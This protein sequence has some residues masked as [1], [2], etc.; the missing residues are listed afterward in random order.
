MV[1]AGNV[2]EHFS[3]FVRLV[4][5]WII[6]GCFALLSVVFGH[7]FGVFVVFCKKGAAHTR[8]LSVEVAAKH[9]DYCA[10]P[11]HLAER[12][13]EAIPGWSLPPRQTPRVVLRSQ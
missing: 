1:A 3:H 2:L 5:F 8:T 13:V 10:P 11:G 6:I 4:C 7:P 12:L 9:I